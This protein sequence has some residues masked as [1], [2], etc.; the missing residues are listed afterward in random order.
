MTFAHLQDQLRQRRDSLPEP[1]AVRLHRAIS[2]LLCAE[3]LQKNPDLQFITLW[4]AFNAC[5][6]V[7]EDRPNSLGERDIF[8]RFTYKLCKH[9]VDLKIHQ[10]LM[11]TYSGPIRTLIS[12]QYVYAPFW[13]AQ[14]LIT[15]NKPDTTEWKA[16]FEKSSKTAMLFLL[17][18]KVP[19]LLSVVLDR[20]Y[21]LRNQLMHGGA[22]WNSKVNRQQVN[23]GARIMLTLVPVLIE[24]MMNSRDEDWGEIYYPV[25]NSA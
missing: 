7:D 22:T 3:E 23:D 17:E 6:S 13:E 24:I 18:K 12:N 21:V 15:N 16:R 4:I 14:R 9:D 20:L 25:V 5:Y 19:D 8:Q 2:W 1:Q 10:T 11:Q